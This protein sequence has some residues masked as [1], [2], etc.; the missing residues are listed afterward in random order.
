MYESCFNKSLLFSII[1]VKR[2][3]ILSFFVKTI[4]KS[5][6]NKL[7][8]VKNLFFIE[9]NASFVDAFKL[10]DILFLLGKK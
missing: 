4:L 3:N 5:N 9:S 10:S 6:I 2:V 1:P 8:E 7:N